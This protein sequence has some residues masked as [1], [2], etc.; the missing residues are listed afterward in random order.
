M[1]LLVSVNQAE[2]KNADL[3]GLF[4]RSQGFT[5]YYKIYYQNN[6]TLYEGEVTYDRLRRRSFIL[7]FR[8]VGFSDLKF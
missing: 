7:G 8:R 3:V 1:N 2:L 5:Y 6:G 4:Q